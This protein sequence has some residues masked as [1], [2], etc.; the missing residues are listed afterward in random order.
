MNYKAEKPILYHTIS[1]AIWI[2]IFIFLDYVRGSQAIAAQAIPF[3]VS[4]ITIAM[5]RTKEPVANSIDLLLFF[6][7]CIIVAITQDSNFY[8]GLGFILPSAA[9]GYAIFSAIDEDRFRFGEN[10]NKQRKLRKA[11][12]GAYIISP[13]LLFGLARLN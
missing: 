7:L 2:A 6:I 10:W 9:I 4:S 11:V 12:I 5:L 1:F 13:I 3:V 8:F